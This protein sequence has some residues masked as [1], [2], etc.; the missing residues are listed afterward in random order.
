VLDG[1]SVQLARQYDSLQAAHNESFGYGWRFTLRDVDLQTD[2]PLTGNEDAGN[3]NAF[4]AGTRVY[5]T[6]PT[7][8][9]TAFTF[10]PQRHDV[11]G[12]SYYTPVFTADAS[13]GWSLSAEDVKLTRAGAR[14]YDLVS[15]LPYNPAGAA[16]DAAPFILTS[17]DGVRY[18]ISAAEGVREIEYSDG[19]RL[20]VTDSGIVAPN[21]DTVRFV[22]DAKGRIAKAIDS[23]GNGFVYLY[24]DAG[25]LE[26]VRNLAQSTATTYGYFGDGAHRLATV[27]GSASDVV[28]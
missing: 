11:A 14:L 12:L 19:I 5:L 17:P 24:N 4:S 7:G 25:N 15:G 27:S 6:L 8:E 18:H 3:F 13:N 21:G 10:G 2:V 26:V 28:I 16:G 9:R 20:A 22:A 23:N 1:H